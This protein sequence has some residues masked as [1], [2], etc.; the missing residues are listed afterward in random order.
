M[1]SLRCVVPRS[2]VHQPVSTISTFWAARCMLI[3]RIMKRDEK[4]P[5][6]RHMWLSQHEALKVF[7]EPYVYHVVRLAKLAR[8]LTSSGITTLRD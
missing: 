4:K 7:D 2:P 3:V 5:E 1:C 6:D 8:L